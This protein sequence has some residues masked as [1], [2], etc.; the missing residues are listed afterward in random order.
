MV[1]VHVPGGG[2]LAG[3][4]FGYKD[5]EERWSVGAEEWLARW[6]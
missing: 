1:M 4:G 2:G 3:D 6:N 5:C